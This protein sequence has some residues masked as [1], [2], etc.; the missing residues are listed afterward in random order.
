M[1]KLKILKVNHK[2]LKSKKLNYLIKKQL[3]SLVL[4]NNNNNND[5]NIVNKHISFKYF[6]LIKVFRMKILH[7]LPP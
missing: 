3:K 2:Y 6:V 5:N 1:L 7:N 4:Y